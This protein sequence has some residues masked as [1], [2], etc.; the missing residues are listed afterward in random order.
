M[1]IDVTDIL[2]GKAADCSKKVGMYNDFFYF[3]C[4]YNVC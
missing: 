2:R 1:E 3:S 4:N